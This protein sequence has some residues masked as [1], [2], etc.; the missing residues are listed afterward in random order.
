[1]PTSDLEGTATVV[2]SL[3]ATTQ[4]VKDSRDVSVSYRQVQSPEGPYV[5]LSRR[6]GSNRLHLS[7]GKLL[8]PGIRKDTDLSSS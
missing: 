5:E 8:L 7:P 3:E 2:G 1:M 6:L 4:R